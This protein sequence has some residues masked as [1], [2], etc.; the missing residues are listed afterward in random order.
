MDNIGGSVA[1]VFP[2]ASGA[3]RRLNVLQ[4]TR[5]FERCAGESVGER[6]Q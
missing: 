1:S 5:C 4:G 2:L 6:C 3:A